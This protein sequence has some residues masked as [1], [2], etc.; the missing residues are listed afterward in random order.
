M[1]TN[2][3]RALPRSL[4]CFAG[5]VCCAA[6]ALHWISRTTPQAVDTKPADL[7]GRASQAK[8]GLPVAGSSIP[9]TP[10]QDSVRCDEEPGHFLIRLRQGVGRADLEAVLSRIGSKVRS[11]M[12]EPRTYVVSAPAGL[13]LAGYRQAIEVLAESMQAY[14]VHRPLER[15]AAPKFVGRVYYSKPDD[16]EEEGLEMLDCCLRRDR[17]FA[18]VLMDDR[19]FWHVTESG[20]R[21]EVDVDATLDFAPEVLGLQ[22]DEH[23]TVASRAIGTFLGGYRR[24]DQLYADMTQ[25]ASA[26]PNLVESVVYGNSYAKQQGGIITPGGDF[27]AGYSLQAL[28][29][30]NKSTSGTKPAFFLIGNIHAREITTPELCMRFVNWLVQGHGVD[31]DATWLLDHH[32]IW[33]IPTAN[34]DGHWM[35]EL[36]TLAKYGG[37][38]WMWRKTAYNIG[39]ATWPP[40]GSNHFGVDG[41]RNF[42]FKWGV[43]GTSTSPCAI[44]YRGTGPASE[45]EVAGIQSLVR[46]R[47]ADQRGPNIGD[48][49]PDSTTGILIQLHSHGN[50]VMWPWGHTSSPVPNGLGLSAIGRKY[51]SYNGYTAGQANQ[52]LYS[53]SGTIDEWAY[54]ELGIS[55]HIFEIGGSFMPTYSTVDSTQWPQNRG[56]F[57]YAA[58]I[59]R[60]PYRMAQGPDACGLVT[61]LAGST[62]SVTATADDTNNG[63]QTIAA[64][65]AFV[66]VPPWKTGATPI[67]LTASD[68]SFNAV[69]EGVRASFS[70]S[71]LSAGRHTVFVR[72][73]DSANNWGPVSAAFFTVG[74]PV[75]AAPE[76]VSA[77]WA[78]PNPVTLANTTTVNVL[79]NDPDSGPAA[80]TYTWSKVSGPGTVTFSPNGTTASSTSTASFSAAGSYVLRVSVSDSAA[81]VT[82]DV[83][84]SVLAAPPPPVGQLLAHWKLDEGGGTSASDA[85][86]NG[87]TGTLVNAPT[88]VAG[89]SGGALSFNKANT[90]VVVPDFAYAPSG[91]FSTAFWVKQKPS[92]GTGFRYVF[93]HGAVGAKN[94]VNVYFVEGG[95]GTLRT[96]LA[97]ANDGTAHTA[98]DVGGVADDVW[99][100]Y[101][102]TVGPTGSTVY[103]DGVAR[104]SSGQGGGAF[105]PSGSLYLGCRQDLDSARFYGG[106]LDDVR[107]YSKTLS[108]ADVQA[109]QTPV[110][111]PTAGSVGYWKLDESSGARAD[112]SMIGNTLADTG[113]VGVTSGAVGNAANFSGSNRLSIANTM[114]Q[115]LNVSESLTLAAWIKPSATSGNR[116]ILAKYDY[117]NNQRAYRLQVVAGKLQAIISPDGKNYTKVTGTTTLPTGAWRHVAMVF[118]ASARTMTLY[119]DGVA[120]GTAT[121]A[122]STLNSSSALFTIGANFTNG[123]PTQAFT[124]AIDEARVYERALDQAEVQELME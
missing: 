51:A 102:L 22:T 29:L 41:N 113:G 2:P 50:L 23:S 86:G 44:T 111:P 77:P 42:D 7:E 53:T 13:S 40:S 49:A 73:R 9:S 3:S 87:R 78:D 107:V 17:P 20:L 100:H 93:S 117:G 57:I 59:A 63:G 92:S 10:V 39:C 55:A 31:A 80:L 37:S 47:I 67:A 25:I 70:V 19:E 60:E 52:T 76:I 85:S 72:G 99:H 106:L 95:A 118:D 94:S 90:R 89:Q 97:D 58:K 98:L 4:I 101:A 45:P 33:V 114:Q 103:I 121:T 119:V 84:V 28:K 1:I 36:G 91:A 8:V 83:S 88:W 81:S 110:A 54:G 18:H 5:F 122:F 12:R 64:A 32:E 27:L 108:D 6:I 15:A 26:Y 123:S 65:Q 69:S 35:V 75:N 112:S 38:P 74:T 116:T 79:A 46:S 14:G 71:S 61:A 68:G 43:A 34:P 120:N 109:L 56:A 82:A 96:S 11:A 48:V 124:G 104:K 105:E 66:N 21:V 30:T 16:L 24:V 115:G 62:L